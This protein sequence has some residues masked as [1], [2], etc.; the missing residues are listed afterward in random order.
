M[1]KAF[2]G[3]G[4]TAGL[5]ADR[6]S[7]SGMSAGQQF[8]ETDTKMLYL[9]DGSV[10]HLVSTV[11]TPVQTFFYGN[12]CSVSTL[13]ATSVVVKPANVLSNTNSAYN[14]STGV[15]TAPTKGLYLVNASLSVY[16]SGLDSAYVELYMNVD[17]T[18]YSGGWQ[19]IKYIVTGTHTSA[20]INTIVN[21]NANSTFT[22]YGR[23]A[24]TTTTYSGCEFMILNIS[25]KI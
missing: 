23:S 1:A 16:S 11:N 19:P 20:K 3:L 15:F 4:T 12:G 21:C 25:D 9:W 8:F 18:Y 6:T 14:A 13:S 17:G 10:W 7:M 24:N 5:A 22:F 2:G